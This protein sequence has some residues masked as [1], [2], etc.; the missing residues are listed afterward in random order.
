MKLILCIKYDA[1]SGGETGVRIVK[2]ING[3]RSEGPV[4]HGSNDENLCWDHAG[5]YPSRK[6]RSAPTEKEQ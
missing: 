2:E 4:T 5:D 6:S 3:L 1:W